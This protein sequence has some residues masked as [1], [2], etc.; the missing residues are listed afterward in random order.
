MDA[1]IANSGVGKKRHFVF[2]FVKLLHF[3]IS[4]VKN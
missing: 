1:A 4:A 3:K 2:I